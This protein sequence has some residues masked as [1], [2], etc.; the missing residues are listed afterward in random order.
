VAVKEPLAGRLVA[1]GG[2]ADQGL[3]LRVVDSHR[4]IT[5]LLRPANEGAAFRGLN[6]RGRPPRDRTIS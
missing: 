3:G 5:P 2:V 6:A 4:R 1:P